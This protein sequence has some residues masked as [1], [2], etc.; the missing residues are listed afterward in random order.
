MVSKHIYMF[1]QSILTL[2]IV[3]IIAASSAQA[4][5]SMDPDML[6]PSAQQSAISENDTSVNQAEV[7]PTTAAPEKPSQ[8]P[9]QSAATAAPAVESDS[10]WVERC[11]DILKDEKIIGRYCEIA[12]T[13]YMLQG[14]GENKSAQRIA[15]IA[16]GFPIQNEALERSKLPMGALVL[17]HGLSV[18]D[19]I[20][21]LIDNK[22]VFTSKISHCDAGGC[23]SPFALKAGAVKQFEK[24]TNMVVRGTSFT[25]QPIEIALSLKGFNKSFG[26]IKQ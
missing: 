19:K 3:A 2:S 11:D 1:C 10:D 25:K 18:Q 17:P 13:L 16:I 4:Q 5:D 8:A 24:G 9:A 15:E 7:A 14:E 26:A 6:D 21:L 23:Y 22:K 20:T 12:Q